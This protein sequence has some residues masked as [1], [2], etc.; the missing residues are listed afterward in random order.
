MIA[1]SDDRVVTPQ[2]VLPV[3]ELR[4]VQADVTNRLVIDQMALVEEYLDPEAS[5]P[6]PVGVPNHQPLRVVDLDVHPGVP[7][8]LPVVGAATSLDRAQTKPHQQKTHQ[9]KSD[10]FH[11]ANLLPALIKVRLLDQN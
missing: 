3:R 8:G 6:R 1:T 11:F 9:T 10:R 5:H 4:R 2:N 7:F